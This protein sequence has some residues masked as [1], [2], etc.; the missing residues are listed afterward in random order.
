MG[1]FEALNRIAEKGPPPLLESSKRTRVD[2]R[3]GIGHE[4]RFARS[5]GKG[6]ASNRAHSFE[7]EEVQHGGSAFATQDSL[8]DNL[9]R[10]VQ[11]DERVEHI[12]TLRA[13]QPMVFI[14]HTRLT[15]VDGGGG[16]ETVVEAS[17]LQPY[18]IF[19]SWDPKDQNFLGNGE[20]LPKV[21]TTFWIAV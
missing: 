20:I 7:V 5:H 12:E 21:C 2:E 15:E 4:P 19:R 3:A 17:P 8:F 18:P 11:I 14:Y 1:P 13:E 9:D 6:L 10:F 16:E